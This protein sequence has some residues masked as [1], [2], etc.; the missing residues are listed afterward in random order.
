M[1]N[2][3][4][5]EDQYEREI[6]QVVRRI[7]EAQWEKARTTCIGGAGLSTA[8]LFLLTQIGLSGTSLSISFFSAALAIPAWLT[9]WQIGEAYSF[10]G[11]SSYGHF[12]KIQGSGIGALIFCI[13]GLLLLTSFVT[14]IWHFSI[15]S[16]L[17]FTLASVAM[18]VFVYRHQLAVRT[19][20]N[21]N[22]TT[23]A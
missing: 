19:W 10:F 17:A 21:Q 1:D 12:S 7:N 14:L 15:I 18:V 6:A 5:I 3:S 23:G 20:V 16:S 9:V 2:Q 4:P 22:D 13:G 8:I 11:P